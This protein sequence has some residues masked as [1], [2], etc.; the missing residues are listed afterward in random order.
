[1]CAVESN[2]IYLEL[3]HAVTNN[4]KS[5]FELMRAVTSVVILYFVLVMCA[6][7]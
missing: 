1:M 2:V 5:Y 6:V 4:I 7:I 3:M